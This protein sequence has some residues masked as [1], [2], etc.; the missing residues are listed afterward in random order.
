VP[1]LPPPER[2]SLVKLCFLCPMKGSHYR[3]VTDARKGKNIHSGDFYLVH[4]IR[5]RSILRRCNL[6][7]YN[8]HS[9]GIFDL[10]QDFPLTPEFGSFLTFLGKAVVHKQNPD[11]WDFGKGAL[12]ANL[13]FFGNH[14]QT[15]GAAA[16]PVMG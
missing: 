10:P 3:G 14:Y 6:W 4:G 16:K 8:G 11:T 15:I 7:A 5:C 13:Y 9:R 2:N 12:S 1:C